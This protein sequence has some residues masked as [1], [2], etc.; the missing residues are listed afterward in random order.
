MPAHHIGGDTIDDFLHSTGMFQPGTHRQHPK[1]H[2]HQTAIDK[3]KC[4][5]GIDTAGQEHHGDPDKRHDFNRGDI[6]RR[7]AD[8]ADQHRNDNRGL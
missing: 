1:Q 6:Y 2:A 3:P 4:L 8:N 5:V 7:Q